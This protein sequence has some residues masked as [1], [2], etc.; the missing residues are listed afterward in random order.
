[1]VAEFD[2]GP[3][4]GAGDGLGFGAEAVVEGEG[5]EETHFCWLGGGWELV[6]GDGFGWGLLAKEM[7]RTIP[8]YT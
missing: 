3:E 7:W 2:G 8:I 5:V 4:G 1:M 6:L